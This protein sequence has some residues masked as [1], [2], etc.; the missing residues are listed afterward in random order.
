MAFTLAQ[1]S[2]THLGVKTALF[3]A[4]FDRVAVALDAVRPDLIVASGDVS[5]DGADVEADLALAAASFARLSAPVHAIPGN[6]DVGDHPERAPHQPVSDDRLL[7]FRRTMG[8]DRWMVDHG[9]WRILGLDSQVMGA[10]P[11]EHAQATMIEDALATL[12]DRR[13]AVF[14]HKPFFTADPD[15]PTFDYW[16]VPPFARG[17]LRGIIEH[18]ALRLV[19]SGHLHLHRTAVRGAVQYAWAPSV[20]F[21]VS[22]DEQEGLPGERPC[23]VLIHRFGDDT[24]ETSLLEPPGMDRPFIHEVRDQTYP[25]A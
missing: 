25:A 12:C 15:E 1:V 19:A 8:P 20:A 6:H 9:N 4:N 21:V 2:D 16:A 13:L 22:P 23:G 3:R 17:P 5:L 7:R 11:E 10:H 18:P 14:I 24:V